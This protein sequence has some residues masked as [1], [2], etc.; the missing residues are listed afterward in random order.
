MTT[1]ET[2][3]A[4]RGEIFRGPTQIGPW[5]DVPAARRLPVHSAI[6]RRLFAHAVGKLDVRVVLPDG[7]GWGS[8]DPLA[9]TISI[10][11]PADFFRRFGADGL[12]GFGE[13]YIAGDWD[14]DDLAAALTPFAQR[15]DAH[16]PKPLQVA[17]HWYQARQPAAD[18]NH[19][20]GARKNISRH[21]DL[22]NDLFA[23]FLDQTMTY[24]SAIFTDP[25]SDRAD[26]SLETAQLR[27]IDRLLDLARVHDG[28]TV[29][30]IGTGWGAL[31]IRAAMRGATVTTLTLSAEQQRVAQQR[32]AAAGV[33]D[34]VDVRLQDYREATGKYD[35]VV[36][37]EMIEAVGEKY[38]PRYFATI[39]E[40]LAPGGVLAL[41]AI[42]IDHRRLL[43]TRGTYTWIHKYVFPG[44][45]LP[46]LQAIDEV[47]A[48][49]THLAVTACDGFGQHYPR[50]LHS[51]LENF[52]AHSLDI[53]ELGFDQQFLRMWEFYLAYCEAG[54]RAGYI[55]VHQL[56]RRVRC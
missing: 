8:R 6:A 46:S 13:S 30:E 18:E 3:S 14:A 21:Y 41:Q 7:R 4:D 11:R 48:S 5:Q 35:A 40:L 28:S 38:W 12:I 24:S 39:D 26:E 29:L 37:V 44:G 50:T 33:G 47:L 25:T 22:S 31:A 54:F 45:I 56:R 16:V 55:D 19:L 36:S 34:R 20:K 9:P 43:A 1:T 17:R 2:P 53:L 52:R 10:H 27:K 49:D 51:W 32:A 42:T 15:V 23:L